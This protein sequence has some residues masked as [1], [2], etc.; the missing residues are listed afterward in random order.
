MISK[1]IKTI[2]RSQPSK[3]EIVELK[4]LLEQNKPKQ[5]ELKTLELIE[6]HDDQLKRFDLEIENIKT[7]LKRIEYLTG[8]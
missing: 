8:G 3:D 7:L 6:K 4:T 5:I 1:D 2:L